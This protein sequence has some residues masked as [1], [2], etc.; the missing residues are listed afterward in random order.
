MPGAWEIP[1]RDVLVATLTRELVATKWAMGYR[2]LQLPGSAACT[3][4]SGMPFD[5]A[6]NMACESLL[7]NDFTW[8]FFL[9]DD[10]VAPPDIYGRLVSHGKDIISGLYY[11]RADPVVPVMLNFDDKGQ[12]QSIKE[13][14]PPNSLLEVDLVGAGCLLI[15]RRVIERMTKPWFEWELG[16][17]PPPNPCKNCGRESSVREEC[18]KA[19]GKMH[20]PSAVIPP[21]LSEDFAFCRRAKR[22]FGFKIFVDT[23]VVCQHVG[24]GEAGVGGFIP[25]HT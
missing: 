15:H 23:S 17:E 20:E 12:A 4:L 10:V 18:P 6:R 2:A 13:W 24:L 11:R 19:S 8:L 3:V 21:R 14:N 25:S 9:D 22:D 16:K 1:R 5:H 7:N